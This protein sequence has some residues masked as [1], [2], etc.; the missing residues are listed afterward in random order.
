MTV[1]ITEFLE[2][3]IAEDEAAALACNPSPWFYNGYAAIFSQPMMAP[4]SEWEDRAF[5]DGH[6]LE[7]RGGCLSCGTDQCK[8]WATDYKRD[9][10]IAGI[11]AQ[12]G[13]TATGRRVADA[14][15]IARHDPARALAE[16]A[17]KR[18]ILA[19]IGAGYSYTL[20]PNFITHTTKALASVYTD[21]PDYRQEW[22]PRG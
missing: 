21:H 11:A 4:H 14:E 1:T 13:D 3:R 12:Y 2:A 17:A 22:A 6:S 16:C 9:S 8:Q 5:A 7:R 20:T 15:H 10:L 18:E 19:N